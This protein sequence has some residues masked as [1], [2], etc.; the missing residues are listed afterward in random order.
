[1]YRIGANAKGRFGGQPRCAP[2]LLCVLAAVL[3]CLLPAASAILF[4]P[5]EQAPQLGSIDAW[6]AS[7][8][9]IKALEAAIDDEQVRRYVRVALEN[10]TMGF[11]PCSHNLYRCDAEGN[12]V[13]V[14]IDYL[15]HGRVDWTK[16]PESVKRIH[17]RKSSLAQALVLTEL[18]Q[19]L[20]EFAAVDTTWQPASLLVHPFDARRGNAAPPLPCEPG[21]GVTA[22]VFALKTLR[23]ENCALTAAN[24]VGSAALFP[25]LSA[26]NLNNNSLLA[27][28]VRSVPPSVV[29]LQ[30]SH[31]RLGS[32][33][34]ADVMRHGPQHLQRL[35]LSFTGLRFEWDMLLAAPQSLVVVDLSGL[36]P[37][38]PPADKV[39]DGENRVDDGADAAAPPSLAAVCTGEGGFSPTELYLSHCEIAGELPDLRGC[40]RLVV[41]EMAHNRISRLRL[42]SL[43]ASLEV[44]HLNNNAFAEAVNVSQLPRGLRSL[45]LS[46]NRFTGAVQV[47]DL[48]AK[49]EYLDVSNNT[50]SGH[51]NLTQLPESMKF[52]YVQHN[53]FSGEADLVEIPLGIRFIMI[54]HNNWDYRLPA[55]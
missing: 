27:F 54:H 25:N 41:L 46:S 55:P 26:L 8:R 43:P 12:V 10:V 7:I 42:E 32:L 37:A 49:L 20:E 21:T 5:I 47:A 18:P 13:E 35:N 53:N 38:S 24:L 3:V 30:L 1:M 36:S 50:L 39:N 9:A 40:G 17:V 14:V 44:L 52:V 6:S 29:S 45:D 51:L 2:F 28:D 33:R 23:C 48:P 19:Q 16:F 34:V 31:T 15:D 4:D 22:C 11:L